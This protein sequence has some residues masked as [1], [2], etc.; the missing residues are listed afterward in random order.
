MRV[1]ETDCKSTP[2]IVEMYLQKLDNTTLEEKE[3]SVRILIKRI[4]TKGRRAISQEA[5]SSI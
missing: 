4:K 3:K 1:Y 2:R 5:R